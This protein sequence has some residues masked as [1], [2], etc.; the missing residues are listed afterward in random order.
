MSKA[1][2]FLAEEVAT[3]WINE[4]EFGSIV[5]SSVLWVVTVSISSQRY[6]T[7]W[8]SELHNNCL[9]DRLHTAKKLIAK[10]IEFFS[11]D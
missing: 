8:F 3:W 2:T 4:V 7:R 9:L 1:F 6:R 10:E 5:H 11:D